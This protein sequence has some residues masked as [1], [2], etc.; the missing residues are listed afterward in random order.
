[1]SY[2]LYVAHHS[3]HYPLNEPPSWIE[4]HSDVFDSAFRRHYAAAVTHLDH[5]VGRLVD[6]LDRAGLR[7]ERNDR[8]PLR[9]RRTGELER[10]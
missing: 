7:R 9:Q 8:L 10:P 4:P 5:A 6:A 3:P 1:M 2:F